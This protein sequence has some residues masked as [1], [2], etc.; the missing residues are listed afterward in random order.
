MQKKLTNKGGYNTFVLLF[1]ESGYICVKRSGYTTGKLFD[2]FPKKVSMRYSLVRTL[3]SRKVSS[4][5]VF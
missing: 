2:L 3:F 4:Y 1:K 5:E